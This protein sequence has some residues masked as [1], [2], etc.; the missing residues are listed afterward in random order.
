MQFTKF[1]CVKIKPVNLQMA[2]QTNPKLNIVSIRDTQTLSATACLPVIL[3]DLLNSHFHGWLLLH[4]GVIFPDQARRVTHCFY[5]SP[6][7]L[8]HSFSCPFLALEVQ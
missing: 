5:S 3:Q 2:S 7:A 8:F 4:L 1:K 6:L